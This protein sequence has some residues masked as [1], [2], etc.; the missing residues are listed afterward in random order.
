[1]QIV[2]HFKLINYRYS[3]SWIVLQVVYNANKLAKLVKEK[4]SKQNWLDYYNLKYSRN[5]S[6]RPMMKVCMYTQVSSSLWIL[7]IVF[8][9]IKIIL[10][11]SWDYCSFSFR[12]S[13]NILLE[14]A[15]SFP[16]PLRRK[17]GC[18]Q[19]SDCWSWKTIERGNRSWVNFGNCYVD[20][21]HWKYSWKYFNSPISTT[22]DIIW[23]LM[24]NAFIWLEKNWLEAFRRFD[25]LRHPCLLLLQHR[26]SFG[27]SFNF[28]ACYLCSF[29]C[30]YCRL[31][32]I[33]PMS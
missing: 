20:W 30:Y 11:C 22:F 26:K 31:P 18:Y 33:L 32:F 8:E 14:L 28:R 13:K 17:S 27:Q 19:P 7:F 3:C 29:Y 24:P 10:W 15:D 12:M 16:W 21:P 4:N 5:K 2:F 25:A 23:P 9:D 6:K 1:M